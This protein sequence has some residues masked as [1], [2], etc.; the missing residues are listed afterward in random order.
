MAKEQENNELWEKINLLERQLSILSQEL[1]NRNSS[2][3]E[4]IR[5]LVKE[6]IQANSG[7]ND[8]KFSILNE[9]FDR[10]IKQYEEDRSIQW[11]Y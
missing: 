8:Q 3:L 11:K 1:N 9:K 2:E 5:N 10:H 4:E 6:S 7:F